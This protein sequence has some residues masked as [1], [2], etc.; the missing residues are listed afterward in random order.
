MVD[1][2]WETQYIPSSK[3]PPE[4]QSVQLD[5]RGS[6]K[7]YGKTDFK[8]SPENISFIAY[9]YYHSVRVVFLE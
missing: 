2:I 9:L 3:A 7:Q 5:F 6:E 8:F 1:Y 4:S